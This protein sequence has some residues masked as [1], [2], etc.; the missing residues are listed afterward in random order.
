V[1]FKDGEYETKDKK[2]IAKLE[3]MK[4]FNFEFI[5]EKPEKPDNSGTPSDKV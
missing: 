5:E 2:V 4:S 3:K 1:N